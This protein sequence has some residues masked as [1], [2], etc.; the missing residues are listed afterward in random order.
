MITSSR[1]DLRVP[2]VEKNDAKKLGARW[3]PERQTWYV[4]PGL[5]ID[6]FGRWLLKVPHE[7]TEVDGAGKRGSLAV[8]VS[9]TGSRT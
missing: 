7:S 1:V 4:P 8:V 3:D 2:Y 5:E 9:S 6:S